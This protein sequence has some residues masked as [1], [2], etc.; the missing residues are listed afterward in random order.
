M[1]RSIVRAALLSVSLAAGCTTI[2]PYPPVPP[3]PPTAEVI[4]N[5]PV[6][7][8]PL[9]WQPGHWNWTGTG[10]AWQ[11]GEYVPRGTHSNMFM[12]GFWQESPSGWMWVPAHWL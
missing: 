3:P 7:D 9:I 6:T 11:P 5:P 8:V 12:P 10:Y 4:P 1:K 2:N